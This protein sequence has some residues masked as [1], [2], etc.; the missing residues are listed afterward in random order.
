METVLTYVS[1]HESKSLSMVRVCLR[2]L[3]MLSSS[4]SLS[5]FHNGGVTL[6]MWVGMSVL[7]LAQDGSSPGHL[8][9]KKVRQVRA[10]AVWVS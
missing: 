3:Q 6:L 5:Q 1:E 2:S 8:W 7:V 9:L 10:G 4:S